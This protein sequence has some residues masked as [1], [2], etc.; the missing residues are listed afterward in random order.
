MKQLF[1]LL[2]NCIPACSTI[3]QSVAGRF[4]ILS[5]TQA[6][7]RSETCFGTINQAYAFKWLPGL[8]YIVNVATIYKIL[9]VIINSNFTNMPWEVFQSIVLNF[10]QF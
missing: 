7:Q 4:E 3:I 9:P 2:L 1:E 8:Q 10:V 6:E 5:T